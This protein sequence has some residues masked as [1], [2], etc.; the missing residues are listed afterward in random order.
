ML[1]NFKAFKAIVWSSKADK[2]NENECLNH[3]YNHDPRNMRRFIQPR[4]E[5]CLSEMST[6][7]RC[8]IH[9]VILQMTSEK[10]NDGKVQ[11]QEDEG[12]YEV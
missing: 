5:V 7:S 8:L 10:E 9:A 11:E 12:V 4:K 2:G 6:E 1:I 3:H